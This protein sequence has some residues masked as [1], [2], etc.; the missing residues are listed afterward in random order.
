MKSKT[1]FLIAT[2]FFL[3]F[4]MAKSQTLDAR[5]LHAI[6]THTTPFLNSSST[7]LSNTTPYVSVGLPVVLLGIG[8]L[9][10]DESLTE[11]G[12]YMGSSLVISSFFTLA[13]KYAVDRP[14]PYVSYPGYIHPRGLEGS[15][16][17]PS[18]HTSLAFS[19][20]T[21]LSMYCPKWYVIVPSFTWAA[22]VG[23]SRMNEGV[24]YPSDVLVGAVFGAGSA[25][26]T[27]KLNK[28]LNRPVQR[29]SHHT[30]RWFHH[31]DK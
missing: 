24:H 26:L 20:A 27:F 5:W 10:N 22:A 18:G 6:N 4:G 28:W 14:R 21:S 13:T 11:G 31:A 8:Y 12:W 23:Y 7:F 16:S 25:W 29:V 15:P 1:I 9:S 2:I 19:T 17:F 30:L 3:H